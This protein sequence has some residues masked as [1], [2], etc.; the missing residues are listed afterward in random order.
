MTSSPL[1]PL[2]L[3]YSP[4]SPLLQNVWEKSTESQNSL[5]GHLPQLYVLVSRWSWVGHM[6]RLQ[7]LGPWNRDVQA[8]GSCGTSDAAQNVCLL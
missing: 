4:A 2:L 1:H 6:S 7:S 5:L 8:I 3:L